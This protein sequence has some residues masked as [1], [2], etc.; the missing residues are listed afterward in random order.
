[1]L[2]S[3]HDARAEWA[4]TKI[5]ILSSLTFR[6]PSSP[7]CMTCAPEGRRMCESFRECVARSLILRDTFPQP[8]WREQP[9]R[10][11]GA[12]LAGRG[13]SSVAWLPGRTP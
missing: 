12:R 13:P 1:V 10:N 11:K 5:G 4:A 9:H 3:L 8:V 7:R 6:L 2:I